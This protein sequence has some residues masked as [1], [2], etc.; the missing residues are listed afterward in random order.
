[1]YQIKIKYN[2]DAKHIIKATAGSQYDCFAYDI[3]ILPHKANQVHASK[4]TTYMYPNEIL[5][6]SLGFQLEMPDDIEAILRSRSGL[7]SEGIVLANGIGTIDSDYRGDVIAML[8]STSHRRFDKQ[9]SCGDKICQL[10][11]QKKPEIE[12]VT[13]TESLS[14]TKRDTGGFGSTGK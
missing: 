9:I 3:V 2:K 4:W 7:A 5:R 11:F 1:M 13:E 14:D 6:I 10:A 12:L 8:Y